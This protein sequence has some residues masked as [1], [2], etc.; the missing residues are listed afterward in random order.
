MR[1]KQEHK[2]SANDFEFLKQLLFINDEGGLT[3][4]GIQLCEL[5][6]VKNDE[7]EANALINM[8]L[9]RSPSTQALLQALSGIKSPSVDQ[10]KHALI[11]AGINHSELSSERLTNFLSVLNA[12]KVLVYNRKG[13]TLRLLVSPKSERAPSH[14]YIDRTRPYSNDAWVREILSECRGA[15]LWLDKY[16][17]K[18]AFEWLWREAS[19]ENI[20][21]ICIISSSDGAIDP[22]ALK[23]Y[24]RLKLELAEKDI[25]LEW[26]VLARSESHTLHDRWILDD[27]SVCYNIPSV[28]SIKSGQQSELHRSPNHAEVIGTFNQYWI[29]AQAV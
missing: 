21:R 19:A 24:K 11:F 27:T 25:E 2:L 1:T 5:I 8:H 20:N 23:D 9:Q 4:A 17:Q 22:L 28:N 14:V 10:A 7:S 3:I 18:E 12:G 6:Y 16:F 29:T 15:V 26:R 13:K